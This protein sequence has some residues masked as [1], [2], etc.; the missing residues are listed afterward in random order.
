MKNSQILLTDMKFLGVPAVAQWLKI[1]QQRLGHCRSMGSI[2]SLAQWVK[3]S[4]IATAAVWLTAVA[5]IQSLAWERPY[6]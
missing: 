2:P 4:G 6:A 1:Q 5:W 3:G